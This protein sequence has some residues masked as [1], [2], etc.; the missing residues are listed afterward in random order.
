MGA[1]LRM[2]RFR[3]RWGL[4]TLIQIHH[5]IPLQWKGHSALSEYDI[6][7]RHNLIFMPTRQGAHVLQLRPGRLLH[8]GGHG[9]YNSFVKRRLDGVHHPS[10]VDALAYEL[11]AR[12]KATNSDLPWT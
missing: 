8:D 12:L 7:A 5:V 3:K 10:D 11:R 1:A 4:C 2:R 9:A 6:D